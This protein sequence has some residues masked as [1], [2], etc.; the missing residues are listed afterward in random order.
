MTVV[1]SIAFKACVTAVILNTVFGAALLTRFYTDEIAIPLVVFFG[2]VFDFNRGCGRNFERKVK[3]VVDHDA[4]G[5]LDLL[6]RDRH[7]AGGQCTTQNALNK[8]HDFV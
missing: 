1:Q 5:G 6:C 2:F 7:Q 8:F 3:D 4:S